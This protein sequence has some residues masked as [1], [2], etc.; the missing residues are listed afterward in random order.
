MIYLVKRSGYE[1]ALTAAMPSPDCQSW[2][3][4]SLQ[5][6]LRRR[7]ESAAIVLNWQELET[8]YGD[9]QDLMHYL[10]WEG[11][12]QKTARAVGR[13]AAAGKE[14]RR[15]KRNSRARGS[16]EGEQI[17]TLDQS[18][19]QTRTRGQQKATPSAEEQ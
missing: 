16:Q 9:L 17:R 5:A 14:R 1:L 8:F 11:A 12:K 4:T 10:R 13:Q 19:R 3:Q 6:H 7:G 15:P 2:E 18:R